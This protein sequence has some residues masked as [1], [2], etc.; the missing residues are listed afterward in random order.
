LPGFWRIDT[1][2]ELAVAT[3]AANT[4][5]RNTKAAKVTINRDLK[6]V[7]ATAEALIGNPSDARKFIGRALRCL[8][9]AVTEFKEEV[10]KGA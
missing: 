10:R 8:R 7:S 2:E 3:L 6:K 4:A 9:S 5:T 1:V